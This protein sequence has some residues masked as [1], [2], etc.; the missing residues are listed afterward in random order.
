MEDCGGTGPYDGAGERTEACSTDSGR[1]EA[2]DTDGGKVEACG[3]NGGNAGA[4]SLWTMQS[5][6]TEF[7]DFRYD[8]NFDGSLAERQILTELLFGNT[9][10]ESNNRCFVTEVVNSESNNVEKFDL[11]Y[12]SNNESSAMTSQAESSD[13]FRCSQGVEKAASGSLCRDVSI[14]ARIQNDLGSSGLEIEELPNIRLNGD[15]VPNMSV[16]SEELTN[17]APYQPSDSHLVK[18]HLVESYNKKITSRW[19]SLKQNVKINLGSKLGEKD[20]SKYRLSI[21]DGRE[22]KEMVVSKA[23]ASPVS[24]ESHVTKHLAGPST[25]TAYAV[26]PRPVKPRWKNSCFVELDEGELSSLR[27]SKKDPR[28]LLRYHI[29]QLLTAAGWVVGRRKRKDKSQAGEYIFRTP[30]GRPIREFR[31]AWISCG[32]QLILYANTILPANDCKM[33]SDMAQ[34]SSDLLSTVAQIEEQLSHIEPTSAL[35]YT[36][37][38]LDPFANSVFIDKTIRLLKVGKPVQGKRNLVTDSEVASGSCLISNDMDDKFAPLD[39]ATTLAVAANGRDVS[40]SQAGTISDQTGSSLLGYSNSSFGGSEIVSEQQD[41][42]S[43]NHKRCRTS[44]RHSNSRFKGYVDVKSCSRIGFE[45]I[46]SL[47]SVNRDDPC[48]LNKS[49]CG[50]SF[51]KSRRT[52]KIKLASLYEHDKFGMSTLDHAGLQ[53]VNIEGTRD[54]SDFSSQLASNLKQKRS[55]VH[56]EPASKKSKTCHLKD[57]DLLVSAIIKN[58]ACK[59]ISKE[60]PRKSKH[61][62]KRKSK[63]GSCRLLLRNLKKGGKQFI[64]GKWS[65]YHSRTVLS[66]LIHSGVV[67]ENE[68]IQYQN[69]KDDRVI[70]D[71][72][73]TWNG[74]ICKCCNNLLSVSEFK[75]H[76]GCKLNRP[77]SNIFMESGKSLTLCQ[78]EAWSA[79]YKSKKGALRTIQL[80][81][82]DE[83]DDS[84]GQCGDGGELICC[85][86]CP[87]TFHQACLYKEKLPEG[88]WYCRHCICQICGDLV[89]EKENSQASSGLKC[90]LCE[91]K[92]HE[93]CMEE[94]GITRSMTSDA[95]FCCVS[96]LEVYS[97]LQSRIGFK[98]SL[99]DCCSWTLLRCIPGDQKVHSAQRFV[100]LKAECN[101]KLAVALTI[102][103]E[104]FL[105]MVDQRT[106]IDMIPQ[107]MYNW[108]S[109]FSRLNYSGFHTVVLEKDDVITCVASIRIHGV[110]V[111]EM[112]LIATCSKYRRQGMCRRLLNS[113]E[114]ML[115]S[116]KVKQLV[117][118]AIP[119]LIETWTVGFGFRQLEDEEKQKL[120]DINLMVFPGTVWLKKPLYN[121]SRESDYIMAQHDADVSTEKDSSFAGTG[122]DPQTVSHQNHSEHEIDVRK[123]ARCSGNENWETSEGQCC[124]SNVHLHS[125]EP[126]CLSEENPQECEHLRVSEGI[127]G[128]TSDLDLAYVEPDFICA[129]TKHKCKKL[130]LFE[131]QGGSSMDNPLLKPLSGHNDMSLEMDDSKNEELEINDEKGF[132]ISGK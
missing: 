40:C 78:L 100:A 81:E 26:S 27:D 93:A 115:K 21:S 60:A 54:M 4:S 80:E 42:N 51:K 130:N 39:S 120:S 124:R 67:S 73:A 47:N 29:Y 49:S 55:S 20:T 76:A 101:S 109:Q 104:C 12:G 129:E 108:G 106:G 57:D 58:R 113:I 46:V 48:K 10:S 126:H 128:T 70:K 31:R 32:E 65:T 5:F 86:H 95:W 33:W 43:S 45:E 97:G 116:F 66:W 17:S 34:F 72:I 117:I 68:A 132:V 63:K 56:H 41:F 18:C 59:S 107:V 125:E 121:N 103:E 110:T 88:S 36:W 50:K 84:C 123:E 35:A 99:P 44:E 3:T 14:S 11:S 114:E 6:S 87:S 61:L 37:C 96:C 90:S 28:P 119:T 13:L 9:N 102:M 94:K 69:P 71:G 75:S 16:P 77:C 91:H 53:D 19:Y 24:Q 7:D 118:S 1:T 112:P 79:E 2:C 38:L 122:T 23:I 74:I 8:E 22:P 30:E 15:K 25:T 98:N 85:D 127:V 89:N 82:V 64:E 111:A 131:N 83:N 92:Y 105:P 62:K 52:S